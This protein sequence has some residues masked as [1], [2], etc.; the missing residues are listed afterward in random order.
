[1]SL[2]DGVSLGGFWH[3]CKSRKRCGRSGYDR[4]LT[5]PVLRADYRTTQRNYHG[6]V[7][8]QM[9][10]DHVRANL[11]ALRWMRDRAQPPKQ[12][13]PTVLDGGAR[14]GRFWSDCKSEKRCAKSPCD[15]LLANPVLKT[16]Y[17]N[18][19]SVTPF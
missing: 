5:N 9:N 16:D 6:N 15:Q 7:K 13:D 11:P 4:L 14:L 8:P 3:D 10:V 19:H 18:Y 12:K 17:H 2:Y 1:M